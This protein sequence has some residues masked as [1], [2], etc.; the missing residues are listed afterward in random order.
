MPIS[1]PCRE[2]HT[3]QHH[4]QQDRPDLAELKADI[5]A[6]RAQRDGMCCGGANELKPERGPVVHPVPDQDRREHRDGDQRRGPRI[7]TA[8]PA[9][10]PVRHDN[11]ESN[12]GEKHQR[13]Q[14]RQQRQAGEE[15]GREPPARVAALREPHQR[16]HHRQF[17]RDQRNVGRDLRHQQ[18]VIQRRFH[19]QNRQY[20]GTDVVRDAADDIG[21]QQ[22]RNRHR[23]QPGKPDAEIGIA[24]N[25][26][27]E[28]NEPR[29]HR[30]MIEEGQ[31][32]FLR[33]GPVVGL[34][35]AQIQR[36]GKDASHRRH[37]SDQCRDPK[38][39]LK[40]GTLRLQ[41]G[42]I[43]LC[44]YHLDAED[45]ACCARPYMV[46]RQVGRAF[47]TTPTPVSIWWSDCAV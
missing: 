19:H 23:Q 25:R 13:G 22:L 11:E 16:P 1:A 40:R 20:G 17:E 4:R 18:A 44:D 21:Q 8:Q 6:K 31:R 28:T 5:I 3:E 39:R 34:V 29:D 15:T 41:R 10:T 26:G 7:R 43:G 45:R 9:P 36:A 12:G 37:H 47:L 2:H 35:R 24:E 46:L 30:G 42:F 14:F 38:Q 27:A 32:V 33:P